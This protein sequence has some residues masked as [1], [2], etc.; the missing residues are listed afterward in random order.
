MPIFRKIRPPPRADILGKSMKKMGIF[1]K[2]T[3]ERVKIRGKLSLEAY[4]TINARRATNKD[5]KSD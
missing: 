2:K 4:G 1:L 3:E 5:K